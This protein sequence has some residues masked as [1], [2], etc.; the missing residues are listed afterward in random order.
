MPLTDKITGI[1]IKHPKL[2]TLGIG[3]AVTFV[4]GTAIGMIDNQVFAGLVSAQPIH[5]ASA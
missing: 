5:K 2:V 3:L 1:F 4:V